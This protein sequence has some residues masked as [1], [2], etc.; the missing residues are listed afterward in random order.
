M[1]MLPSACFASVRWVP[2]IFPATPR[3]SRPYCTQPE[4]IPWRHL[5]DS[6]VPKASDAAMPSWRVLSIEV[7]GVFNLN[8]TAYDNNSLYRRIQ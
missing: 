8:M 1:H 2:G 3:R 5:V 6:E 7:G 4:K